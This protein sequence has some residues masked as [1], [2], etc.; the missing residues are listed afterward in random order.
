[1]WSDASVYAQS[2]RSGP[3]PPGGYRMKA[4]TAVQS[5]TWMLYSA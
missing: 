1:M 2:I 3:D 4:W 5:L